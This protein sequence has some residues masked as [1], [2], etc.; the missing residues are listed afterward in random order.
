MLLSR[1]VGLLFPPRCVSC[2]APGSW[3]CV[4]CDRRVVPIG[5][6]LVPGGGLDALLAAA[7]HRDPVTHLVKALKYRH[8]KA[9]VPV[10]AARLRP[11]V[12]GLEQRVPRGNPLLVPV[13]LHPRRLRERGH[14]QSALIAEAL[15][16]STGLP[17][18]TALIRTRHTRAQTG[19]GRAERRRNVEG[20]FEWTGGSL[21]GTTVVLVDDVCT[22]GATLAACASACRD[23]GAAAVWGLVVG[24]R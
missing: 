3:W 8:A 23:A 6:R 7:A 21:R 4:D 22:T 1:L 24:K 12:S 13:P 16:E 20:A 5:A 18:S 10:M 11:L 14:N 19:L 2:T 9:V 17:L 15:S